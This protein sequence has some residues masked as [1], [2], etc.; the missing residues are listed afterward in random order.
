MLSDGLSWEVFLECEA[1]LC[2]SAGEDSPMMPQVDVLLERQANEMCRK[3][4]DME[5]QTAED[6]KTRSRE[7]SKNKR[8]WE[9]KSGQRRGART[10]EVERGTA[11]YL[12]PSQMRLLER[13]TMRITSEQSRGRL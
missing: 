11:I 5:K 7:E 6:K 12:G 9:A 10:N 2:W 13:R 4:D 8:F 1:D 3:N